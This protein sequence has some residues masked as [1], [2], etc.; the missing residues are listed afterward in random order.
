MDAKCREFWL[1]R[2][3]ENNIGWHHQEFNP[4][5]TGFWHRAEVAPGATVLVPLCG[6]SRDMVWLAEQG[7]QVLGVE[8]S[9]LA[10]EAFFREQKLSPEI[11]EQGA[12]RLWQAGPYQILCGDIFQL[13]STDVQDVVGV[14]D[15]ASLVALDPEQRTSYAQLLSAILPTKCPVLLV[16]MD[17]PQQE[18]S[19]PPYCVASSEVQELFNSAFE[20]SQLHDLD[21]LKDTDRYRDKGLSRLSEQIWLLKK[22]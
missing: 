1:Q 19:G 14:Y 13:Q 17:Y 6:K 7:C 18:M 9:P 3:K 12:F 15:R 21:L 16:A 8:L 22:S 20:V 4:H 11:R 5:L 10:V 2:W